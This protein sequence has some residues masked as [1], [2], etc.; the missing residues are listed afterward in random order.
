MNPTFERS[1]NKPTL[2]PIACL[3]LSFDNELRTITQGSSY[4]SSLVHGFFASESDVALE[5]DVKING[6][7]TRGIGTL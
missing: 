6:L 7:L 2:C 1:T 5:E 4:L 3:N